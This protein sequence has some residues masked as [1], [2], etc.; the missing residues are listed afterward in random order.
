M[1]GMQHL[2]KIMFTAHVVFSAGWIGAVASFLVLA[3][4]G[5]LSSDAADASAMYIGMKMTCWYVVVPLSLLSPMTG[6]VQSLI[7]PWRLFRHYW[8]LVKLLMTIPSTLFLLVHLR[9][10]DQLGHAA[11]MM[12]AFSASANGLRLQ[13]I[14]DSAAAIVVL[15]VTVVL[16]VY[17]PRG[18]TPF[19]ASRV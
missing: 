17:K 4:N 2:R 9:P 13:L 19:A 16:A 14:L 11:L 7:T 6:V 1:S 18:L 5:L 10:I 3:I 15:L 8:I 12:R